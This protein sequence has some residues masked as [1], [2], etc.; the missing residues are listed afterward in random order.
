[1]DFLDEPNHPGRLPEPITLVGPIEG[2]GGEAVGAVLTCLESEN[3][4]GYEL[5]LGSDP[6][7]IMDYMVVYDGPT[8]PDT[9]VNELPY[10]ETWWTVRARDQYGSA[11]YADPVRIDSFMLSLPV[12][13][14]TI[15]KRYVSIQVAI[16]EASDGD[17]IVVSP[18]PYPYKEDI[19]LMGKNVTLRST[20]PGTSTVVASTILKGTGQGTVVTFSGVEG[21]DCILAGFTITGGN[22]DLGGGIACVNGSSPTLRHCVITANSAGRAGGGMYVAGG[23]P[24]V[25]NCIL[26]MNDATFM[27]GGISCE[28][29]ETTLKNCVLYGN[30]GVLGAGVSAVDGTPVLVNCIL[31]DNIPDQMFGSATVSYCN[32]EGGFDGEGNFDVDP[33]L[34]DPASGDYH[35]KSQ[36]GRW[37]PVGECW[38]ADDTTSA[39]IDAGD[40]ANSVVNEPEPNGS[41]INMGAYGG[42]TEA[43]KSE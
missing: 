24:S 23:S 33:L 6:Y 38:I 21:A 35:L 28:N 34:V 1:M 27:G 15:N 10:E 43:S 39:C 37:D 30:T 32:V 5:L 2:A 8:P 9:P 22:A 36:A 31:Y 19:D 25:E 14:S 40:P 12:R 41:R 16:D 18:G 13:N 17:E 7:R 29:S 20:A 3:A 4:V 26:S 42:T 11:I